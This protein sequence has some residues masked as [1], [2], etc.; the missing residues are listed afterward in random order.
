MNPLKMPEKR[1]GKWSPSSRKRPCKVNMGVFFEGLQQV[2]N[3][4]TLFAKKEKEAKR[5]K[6][7]L[8]LFNRIFFIDLLRSL[9]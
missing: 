5:K 3:V 2:I 9:I 8:R 4:F 1:M 7:L 6:G